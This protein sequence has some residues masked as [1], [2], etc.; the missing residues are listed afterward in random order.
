MYSQKHIV[1]LFAVLGYII[2]SGTKHNVR[3]L[4]TNNLLQNLTLLWL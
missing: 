3:T 2:I 1:L 4:R